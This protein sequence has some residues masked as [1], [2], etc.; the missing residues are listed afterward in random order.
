MD[1]QMDIVTSTFCIQLVCLWFA[2]WCGVDV[3]WSEGLLVF[4]SCIDVIVARVKVSRELC[5]SP[6][7]D[8]HCGHWST[9]QW[10]DLYGQITFTS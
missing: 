9:T 6:N 5:H 7:G 1:S 3:K 2:W 8:R 10:G 4:C